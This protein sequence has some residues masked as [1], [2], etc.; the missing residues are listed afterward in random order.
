MNRT[1]NQDED[2][3]SLDNQNKSLDRVAKAMSNNKM[4]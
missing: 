1:H 4:D 3:S 2:V